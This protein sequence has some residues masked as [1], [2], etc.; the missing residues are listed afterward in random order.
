MASRLLQP[1]RR[2]RP[3]SPFGLLLLILAFLLIYPLAMIVYTAFVD[4]PPRPGAIG[5][6][7]TWDNIL[8]A[9]SPGMMTVLWDSVSLALGGTVLAFALGG[10]LAWLSARTDVPGR[11]LVQMAGVVPLF[12]PILVGSV[13]WSALAS[14]R[15]GYINVALRDLGI[16]I[17]VNIFSKPGIIFIYGIYYAPYIFLLLNS[18]LVLMDPEQEE[19][20]TVHGGRTSQ[21]IRW[22][23]FPLVRAAAT[24]AS[25]LVFIL[26]LESFTVARIIGNPARVDL[27]PGLIYRLMQAMPTAPTAAA[28]IGLVLT[29]IVFGLI[30]IQRRLMAGKDYSTVRGKGFKPRMIELGRWGYAGT[31]LAALYLLLAFVMP[32]FALFQGTVRGTRITRTIADFFDFSTYSIEEAREVLTSNAFQMALRNS[33]ILGT[34]VALVGG[35]L[36]LWVSYTVNRTKLR[37]RRSLEYL[38]MAPLAIPGIVLGLGFLWAWIVLPVPLYGTLWIMAFAFIAKFSPQAYQGITATI[39]QIHVDLEDSAY[40]SGASRLTTI[41]TVTVPLLRTGIASTVLLLFILSFRELSA[42]ILLYTTRTRVMA[43]LLYEQWTNGNWP[44]T[45]V[46]GFAF[47]LILVVLTLLG[48][49]FLNLRRL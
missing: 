7:F 48:R 21:V 22:I 18:A 2:L 47:S 16:P 10:T 1:L 11:A 15:A 4:V 41:R 3:Y 24:G 5:A 39:N 12:V 9:F 38:V 37:G 44:R 17:T 30:V 27:V 33:L 19:A 20:A 25:I 46:M 6:N 40:L 32:Y 31:A 34:I 42:S 26:A 43:I 36:Y 23:T 29:L 8:R 14:P 13:A 45:A 49:R 35:A 28:A